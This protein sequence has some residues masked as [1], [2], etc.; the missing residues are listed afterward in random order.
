MD[1][2]RTPATPIEAEVQLY[3][4]TE[5]SDVSEGSDPAKFWQRQSTLRHFPTLANIA[6]DILVVPV[7][8]AEVER[9]FSVAGL[10]S[11][12]RKNRRKGSGLEQKV[13]IKKNAAYIE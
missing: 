13:L 11:S 5:Y 4:A 8:S 9:V 6:L 12:D 1:T 10:V 7:A 2:P 3:S